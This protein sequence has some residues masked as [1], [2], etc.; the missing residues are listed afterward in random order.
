MDE[1]WAASADG[2][3]AILVESRQKTD[4]IL[5]LTAAEIK[6][7]HSVPYRI[8]PP[9]GANLVTV[10]TIILLTFTPG[11]DVLVDGAGSYLYWGWNGQLNGFGGAMQALDFLTMSTPQLVP[12]ITHTPNGEYGRPLAD[13]ANQG[14]DLKLTEALTGDALN[15][16]SLRVLVRFETLE[17]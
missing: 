8:V 7:L 6:A 5:T 11:S 9:P 10:P 1:A 15:E 4:R 16:A 2:R 13:L 14:L 3:G 12:W 17:L